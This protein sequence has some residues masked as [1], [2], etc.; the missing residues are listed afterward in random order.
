MGGINTGLKPFNIKAALGRDMFVLFWLAVIFAVSGG[1]F[2]LLSVCC[3][4]GRSP[5]NRDNRRRG[6]TAE[7]TPYTYERVASPYGGNMGG[8]AVPLTTMQPAPQRETAYEPY[9]H[10]NPRY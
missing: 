4:S 8:S 6:V 1:M 2:W 5:Y 7:K 9:R 10:E 3:C